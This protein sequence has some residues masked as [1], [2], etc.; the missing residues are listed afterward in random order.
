MTKV[1][2]DWDSVRIHRGTLTVVLRGDWAHDASWVASF[3]DGVPP[4]FTT[5]WGQ[6]S[7]TA[8]TIDAWDHITASDN[9]II[10]VHALHPGHAR[11]LRDTLESYVAE[12]NKE[13]ASLSEAQK[14]SEERATPA[15]NE[16][17]AR[18]RAMMDE[19]RQMPS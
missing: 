17:D 14:Q 6:I 8:P 4:V 15:Q 18:D 1:K 13:R 16:L 5:S 11:E 7:G 19:F 3:N 10:T 12:A 2:I 9:G